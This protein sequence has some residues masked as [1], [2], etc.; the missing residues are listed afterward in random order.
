MHV[1]ID[2]LSNTRVMRTDVW[3]LSGSR[4]ESE[5]CG[6]C[7]RLQGVA[8]A[9]DVRAR[10][11]RVEPAPLQAVRQGGDS[12]P[13]PLPRALPGPLRVPAVPRHLHAQ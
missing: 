13:Q 6:G 2:R 1:F 4:T 7:C 12:H 10:G 8:H 11:G 5:A 3:R 9:A